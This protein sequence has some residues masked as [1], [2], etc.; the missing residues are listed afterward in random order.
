M[1]SMVKLSVDKGNFAGETYRFDA[2]MEFVVG[3]A[4]DCDIQVPDTSDF[5]AI[6]LHHC[7]FCIEPPRIWLSILESRAGTFVNDLKINPSVGQIRLYDEDEVRLGQVRMSV[8]I[9]EHE[10][11]ESFELAGVADHGFETRQ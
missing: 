9:V 3:R 4:R 10:D 5:K 1:S 6:S 2:P 7:A 11:A 8:H